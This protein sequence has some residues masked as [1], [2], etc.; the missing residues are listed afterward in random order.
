MNRMKRQNGFTII[1]III[2]IIIL[3]LLAAT[4]LPRFL[5]TVDEAEDASLEGVAGAFATGVGLVRGQWEVQGRPVGNGDPDST[6]V[7]VDNRRI[8]IDGHTVFASNGGGSRGYPSADYEITTTAGTLTSQ[9]TADKCAALFRVILQNAPAV[10][11]ITGVAAPT[12][13]QI[14]DN[15]YIARVS[16]TNNVCVYFQTSGMNPAALTTLTA[17]GATPRERTV[18]VTAPAGAT[19]N[20][21]WYDAAS[22][23][24]QVVRGK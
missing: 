13:A 9:I 11:P 10:V 2:V 22:G 18:T 1:E 5:D 17:G 15:K 12:Q 23:Q 16:T 21:F 3:G 20:Y 24:V 14:T 7:T 8:G 4:A 6:F 19:F